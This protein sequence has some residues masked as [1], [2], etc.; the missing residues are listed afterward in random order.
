[1]LEYVVFSEA[2]LEAAEGKDG[3]YGHK[4]QR[5]KLSKTV[6]KT[7]GVSAGLSLNRLSVNKRVFEL[8]CCYKC[9]FSPDKRNYSQ[10][11]VR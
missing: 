11:W 9:Q 7:I 6:Q 10:R 4:R 3:F 8:T 5:M 2:E 1:M